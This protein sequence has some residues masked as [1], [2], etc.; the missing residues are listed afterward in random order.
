[1]SW[2]RPAAR[3]NE[4]Y[5]DCIDG[6]SPDGPAYCHRPWLSGWLWWPLYAPGGACSLH[7]AL[8]RVNSAPSHTTVTSGPSAAKTGSQDASS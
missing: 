6:M 5:A 3:C 7:V 8:Y 2:H 1:M 4:P